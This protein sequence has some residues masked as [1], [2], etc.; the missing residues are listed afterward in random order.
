MK[1]LHR[2]PLSPRLLLLLFIALFNLA[3][4]S[5]EAQPLQQEDSRQEEAKDSGQESMAR[6]E[7]TLTFIHVGKGDAFLLSVPGGGHYLVDTGKKKD[8]EEIQEV[9][10]E[11]GVSS[12]QGIFLSHGH[13]DHAGGMERILE[14]YPTERVYLSGLEDP[15]FEK[16]DARAVAE[17]AG[18]PVEELLLGEELT[19]GAGGKPGRGQAEAATQAGQDGSDA[20]SAAG[21]QTADVRIQILGPELVDEENENNNS[22]IL[23]VVYGETAFLLMGDTELASEERLLA[24]GADIRADV[25]KLGHHGKM[26][27]TSEELLE[28]VGPAYGIVTANREKEEEAA[29]PVM[30]ERLQ[31][32]QMQV[33]YSEGKI[34]GVDFISDGT[35][36]RVE[37]Y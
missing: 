35:E 36:V 6:E 29:D 7:T 26:D 21:S 37:K 8:F 9:L 30:A 27:A 12:L 5:R 13:K 1:N 18:V 11:K 15:S 24:S 25:L 17:E 33:Y 2:R 34:R 10:E 23:R 28:R 4:C 19:L 20:Q 14:E 3:G 32:A 22:L 16:V 31:K